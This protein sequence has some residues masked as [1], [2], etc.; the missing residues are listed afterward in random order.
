MSS[1]G[2]RA[3]LRQRRRRVVV[4]LAVLALSAAIAVAH[5]AP[6]SNH[7]GDGVAM[8]LA[9][10]GV[11][12]AAFL[13]VTRSGMRTFHARVPASFDLPEQVW[14]PRLLELPDKRAG[15]AVLQVFLN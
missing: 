9:I 5:A 12:G 1:I 13:A 6:M 4:V 15:P 8:C 3:L 11:A 14:P 2:I 7:M 10:A